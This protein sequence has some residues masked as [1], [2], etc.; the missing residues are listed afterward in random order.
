[1]TREATMRVALGA[2]YGL[3]ILALW[4]W[5]IGGW[6]GARVGSQSAHVIELSNGDQEDARRAWESL[7]SAQERWETVQTRVAEEHTREN[8][9]DGWRWREGW[10]GQIRFT[11]DFR[12]ITP[13]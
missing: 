4:F 10:N 7:V 8:V 3:L 12:Y 2:V 5:P 1:M 9:D 6:A 13:P 11:A